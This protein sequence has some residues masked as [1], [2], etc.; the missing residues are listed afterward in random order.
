MCVIIINS[1]R[2]RV[3]TV[4]LEKSM[5]VLLYDRFAAW[6]LTKKICEFSHDH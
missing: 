4:K 2:E 1:F 3:A 6:T 5:I